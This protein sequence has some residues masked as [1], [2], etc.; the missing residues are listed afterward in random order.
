M[1]SHEPSPDQPLRSRRSNRL[2]IGTTARRGERGKPQMAVLGAAMAILLTGGAALAEACVSPPG[3]PALPPP[4]SQPQSQP[5]S[6]VVPP[7]TYPPPNNP[8]PGPTVTST[9][10]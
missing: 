1:V 3:G 9:A 4:Q 10:S 8:S 7:P 2:A 5:Q 6:G